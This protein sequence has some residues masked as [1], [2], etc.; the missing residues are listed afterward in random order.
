MDGILFLIKLFF[1]STGG[2]ALVWVLRPLIHTLRLEPDDEVFN[3]TYDPGDE[4]EEL[5]IPTGRADGKPD[6]N[7]M[8][9]NA[10]ED[11][12]ATTVQIQRWLRENKK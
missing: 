4:E 5:E 2:A 1:V 10:R 11:S 8:L 7:T 3:P 6:R 12:R 9:E